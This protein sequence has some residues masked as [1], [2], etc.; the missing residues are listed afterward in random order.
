MVSIYLH[1]RGAF[2]VARSDNPGNA[3][4]F[5]S[6]N[7]WQTG[8]TLFCMYPQIAFTSAK[9]AIRHIESFMS[10]EYCGW[11]YGYDEES[12]YRV[13]PNVEIARQ[14]LLYKYYALSE[15][16][17]DAL[18]NMYLYATHPC[19]FNDPF[20]CNKGIVKI[21]T[22]E[23]MKALWN[24]LYE[25]LCERMGNDIGQMRK[26]SQEAYMAILYRKLGIISLTKS[27][28]NPIMWAHYANNDGFCVGLD[29]DRLSFKHY[30]PFPINYT[31]K[32]ETFDIANSG[33]HLAMLMQT[34][35][36]LPEWS[37]EE[38]WR[39]L[40]EGPGDRYMKGFGPRADE[41][42]SPDDHDRKFPYPM[43][44]LRSVCLGMRFFG[45]DVYQVSENEFDVV[46]ADRSGLAC[47]VMD[48][49]ANPKLQSVNIYVA[50]ADGLAGIK[51]VRIGIVK[52]RDG[53]FRVVGYGNARAF[54]F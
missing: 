20:D 29:V 23:S 4:A 16:S 2:V 5:L 3:K 37:Y 40:V 32:I 27:D 17:V 43:Q 46:Y 31:D 19:Q 51:P 26:Y 24:G 1:H 18:T 12:G 21:T 50:K 22:E 54:G 8:S 9:G 11:T 36:K 7:E 13:F 53:K 48:F 47:K 15:M 28:A 30:G 41:L 44:A 52:L 45:D 33:G 25:E 42:A 6:W 10:R 39:L 38:E 34:N 49:L 35:V 14:D